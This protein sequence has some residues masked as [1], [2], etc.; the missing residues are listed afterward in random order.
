MH[1]LAP[2]DDAF[3]AGYDDDPVAAA[4]TKRPPAPKFFRFGINQM[5]QLYQYGET[6]QSP[7]RVFTDPDEGLEFLGVHDIK[8]AERAGAQRKLY[9]DVTLGSPHP[10]HLFVLSLPVF[11]ASPDSSSWAVRTLLGS[12]T[13]ACNMLDMCS[14]SGKIFTRRGTRANFVDLYA[15]GNPTGEALARVT[16]EAIDGDR[17]SF[18]IAVNRLRRA[19]NLEPQ[20]P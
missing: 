8:A 15:Y 4:I 14:L 9:L 7:Q 10:L 2:A 6:P 11:N 16:A 3:L 17:H 19:L 18:E 5:G 12:L 1:A 13:V 20:F